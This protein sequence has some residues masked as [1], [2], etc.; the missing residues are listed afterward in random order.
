MADPQTRE[1]QMQEIKAS[2]DQLRVEDPEAY[3]SVLAPHIADALLDCHVV[4]GLD[5]IKKAVQ[6]GDVA[7]ATAWC[8]SISAWRHGLVKRIVFEQIPLAS[9]K[10]Q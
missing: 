2:L 9:A 4:E 10:P 5:A 6:A 3:Y 8:E 7:T 1:A